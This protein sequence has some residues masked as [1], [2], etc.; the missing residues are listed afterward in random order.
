MGNIALLRPPGSYFT[1]ML[2]KVL[3]HI[4][5]LSQLISNKTL[6]DSSLHPQQLQNAEGEKGCFKESKEL[7][8]SEKDLF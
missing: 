7:K 4:L 2:A 8:S 3:M 5:L 6:I 1:K